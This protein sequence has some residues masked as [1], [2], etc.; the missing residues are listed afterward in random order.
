M[1]QTFLIVLILASFLGIHA[2]II[3]DYAITDIPEHLLE[4]ANSVIRY[5]EQT[6]E[7]KS[8]KEFITTEYLVV[9][10]FEKDSP[11]S[12]NAAYYNQNSSVIKM[13]G[14]ILDWSGTQVKKKTAKNANDISTSDQST[15]AD[16][17]RVKVLEFDNTQLPYT[18]I[19][20]IQTKHKGGKSYT[21][22]FTI[23][24]YNVAIQESK[25]V[26]LHPE[27]FK[28]NHRH[29]NNTPK[30]TK[31]IY[32]K[33]Q[34]ITWEYNNLKAIKNESYSPNILDIFPHT[35][36]YPIEFSFYGHEGSL[37]DWKSFGKFFS[38]LNK[39]HND[40]SQTFK[41][42]L[43]EMTVSASSDKEKI[44]IIYNYLQKNTRYVSVQLGIG[45][46]KSFPASYVEKNKYGDCKALS[47]FTKSM[48][49]E[50]GIDAIPA[51]IQ[52]SSTPFEVEDDFVYDRFNHI[53]LYVPSEDTWL[54]CTSSDFPVGYIGQSNCN[55]KALLLTENGG[56]LKKTPIIEKDLVQIE[57][58]YTVHE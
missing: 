33:Q 9:T 26:I 23:P 24:R 27:G 55:R 40:M 30:E 39:E 28:F 52:R 48:L 8:K 35:Q 21:P 51:I 38:G 16:D 47:Y 32:K 10:I 43:K 17:S 45:G 57:D 37:Q 31:D 12:S 29:Y 50:V 1:K 19:W 11:F 56:E 58:K 41:D 54:E 42:E 7:I 53:L 14:R 5:S 22:W 13:E 34:R 15:I 3:G 2:Q 49:D 25:H 36:I 20:E 4:N 18:I 44:D 46:F 6:L